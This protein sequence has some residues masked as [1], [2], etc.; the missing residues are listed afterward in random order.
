MEPIED[1]ITLAKL[2][3]DHLEKFYAQGP[4]AIHNLSVYAMQGMLETVS[5]M[6][7]KGWSHGDM[8][9]GQVLLQNLEDSMKVR[10]V[11]LGRAERVS[12][13]PSP[14]SKAKIT[15]DL[16]N[17]LRIFIG[18]YSGRTFQTVSKMKAE[19]R[20]CLKYV[21][22]QNRREFE[23]WVSYAMGAALN[24]DFDLP[25]QKL[26]HELT[27]R[28]GSKH[29]ASEFIEMCKGL[30]FNEGFQD[31]HENAKP[32]LKKDN[33]I[34]TKS[35]KLAMLRKY[36]EE[37]GWNLQEIM[38]KEKAE[39]QSQITP[40][41]PAPPQAPPPPPPLPKSSS[42]MEEVCDG[43]SNISC[44]SEVI[45]KGSDEEDG[46][47]AVD[48]DADVINK[49]FAKLE[50]KISGQKQEKSH[51]VMKMKQGILKLSEALSKS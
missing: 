11:D 20:D 39:I 30:L 46:L 3:E 16:W 33:Q 45:A 23:K 25:G 48:G 14:G 31:M 42:E 40:G 4:G 44:D 38:A 41:G 37:Q 21:P 35:E 10:I 47:D 7:K 49:M 50:S 27:I 17:V 18:L 22:E 1:N 6:H 5:H 24:F 8:H 28:M 32:N 43:L 2:M 19:W 26:L 12:S 36:C 51:V 15:D 29:E 9:G 34:L 13:P